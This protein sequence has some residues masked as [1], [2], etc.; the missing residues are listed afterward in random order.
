MSSNKLKSNT[1]DQKKLKQLTK[2][3]CKDYIA[4]YNDPNIK[5]ITNPITGKE[6]NNGGKISTELHKLCMDKLSQSQSKSKSS[7]ELLITKDDFLDLLFDDKEI[8][9]ITSKGKKFVYEKLMENDDCKD[10]LQLI[11]TNLAYFSE[12][13]NSTSKRKLVTKPLQPILNTNAEIENKLNK[14]SPMFMNEEITKLI[15]S[16][17]KE[18]LFERKQQE[19]NTELENFFWAIKFILYNYYYNTIN[20]RS[21]NFIYFGD[22]DDMRFWPKDDFRILAEYVDRILDNKTLL[23]PKNVGSFSVSR[24]PTSGNKRWKKIT[25]YDNS[26]NKKREAK[27]AE[28]EKNCID[29]FDIITQEDFKEFPLEKLEQIIP[30]G[31]K[32]KKGQKNCYYSKTLYR[33][34][35]QAVNDGKV[36]PQNPITRKDLNEMEAEEIVNKLKGIYPNIEKPV[37]ESKYHKN[38]EISNRLRI[39]HKDALF[40]QYSI[41][42]KYCLDPINQ[43][44]RI[45]RIRLMDLVIPRSDNENLTSQQKDILSNA[46]RILKTQWQDGKII[47]KKFPF[48]FKYPDFPSEYEYYLDGNN[49]IKWDKCLSAANMVLMN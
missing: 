38:I 43:P 26:K 29:M 42:Y 23:Y 27:L 21:S 37:K 47:S 19:T 32:N 20:D 34:Y 35:Q 46:L 31:E 39:S 36:L 11:E 14:L 15:S 3:Q 16:K 22:D 49:N 48:E 1:Y 4:S 28:I 41:K 33:L 5:S 24:S 2:E 12:K 17:L 6:L 9:E 8:K 30:L 45:L 18:Y 10:L 44:T 25:E 7:S 40:T 13:I